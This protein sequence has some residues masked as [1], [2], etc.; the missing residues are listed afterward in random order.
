MARGFLRLWVVVSAF[1]VAVVIVLLGV[2]PTLQI[3]FAPIPAQPTFPR[4]ADPFANGANPFSGLIDAG[5]GKR[6]PF[7]DYPPDKFEPTTG[8]LLVSNW[9]E[10]DRAVAQRR[11]AADSM[12]GMLALMVGPPG[13]LFLCGL[14]VAW[15]YRGFRGAR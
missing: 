1:W 3:A 7:D 11:Q 13:L 15:V 4:Q 9:E 2:I 12:P 14:A 8:K 5:L 6:N 10:W